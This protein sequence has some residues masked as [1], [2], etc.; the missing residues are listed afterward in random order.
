VV[1]LIYPV[2][3]LIGLPSHHLFMPDNEEKVSGIKNFNFFSN[4]QI[5]DALCQDVLSG[6]KQ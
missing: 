3:D 4:I 5:M 1:Y 6:F 2:L